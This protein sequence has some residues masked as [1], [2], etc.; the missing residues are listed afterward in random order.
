MAG[1][2]VGA[3]AATK[4]TSGNNASTVNNS[5]ATSGD[6]SE[7]HLIFCTYKF[8]PRLDGQKGLK[9]F[10]QY[11]S[12]RIFGRMHGALNVGKKNN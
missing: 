11:L 3:L 1:E 10:A 7:I 9:I 12:H 6:G 5:T 8:W 2:T 4:T